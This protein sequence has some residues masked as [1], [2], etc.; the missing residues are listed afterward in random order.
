MTTYSSDTVITIEI[1][2]SESPRKSEKYTMEK[3]FQ[4]NIET[5]RRANTSYTCPLKDITDLI[6][7]RRLVKHFSREKI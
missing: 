6:E 1:I 4:L 5:F 7:Q 2:F 3:T